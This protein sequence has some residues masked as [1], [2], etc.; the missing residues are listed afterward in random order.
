[1]WPTSSLFSLKKKIKWIKSSDQYNGYALVN[2]HKVSITGVRCT[3]VVQIFDGP[4]QTFYISDVLKVD[5][6]MV[7]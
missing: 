3:R 4:T 2:L 6:A 1:M 7:Y 5:V